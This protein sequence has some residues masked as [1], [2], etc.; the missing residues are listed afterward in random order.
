MEESE[1]SFTIFFIRSISHYEIPLDVWK[2]II[3]ETF[4]GY[5]CRDAERQLKEIWVQDRTLFP[6]RFRYNVLNCSIAFP[7]SELLC[8]ERS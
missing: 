3:N 4:R 2:S 6:N 8:S 5:Q 7:P 1:L